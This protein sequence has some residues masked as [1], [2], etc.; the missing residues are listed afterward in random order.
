V[1]EGVG[2]YVL[3][4]KRLEGWEIRIYGGGLMFWGFLV[5]GSEVC[6]M[7]GGGY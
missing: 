7:G 3:G 2:G 5:L 6:S 1:G 4:E